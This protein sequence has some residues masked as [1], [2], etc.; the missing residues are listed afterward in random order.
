M[1]NNSSAINFKIVVLAVLVAAVLAWAY[2]GGYFSRTIEEKKEFESPKITQAPVGKAVSSLPENFS[3]SS[4]PEFT[5]SY[6][7]E[8]PSSTKLQSTAEF[9]SGERADV[10]YDFYLNWAKENGW[11]VS[12]SKKGPPTYSIYLK[13]SGEE[14]NIVIRGYLVTMSYI[15]PKQ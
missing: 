15:Q 11:E 13:K 4:E 8:D 5:K 7:V 9:R 10:N 2:Y 12:N 1:E 6:T 3:Y 14:I